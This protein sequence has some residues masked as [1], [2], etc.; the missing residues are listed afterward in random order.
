SDGGVYAAPGRT[1]DW[2]LG[3]LGPGQSRAV[4]IKVLA[5]KPGDWA[6]QA[7]ARA[8]WGLEAKAAAPV[9]VEGVPGLLLAVADLD[10]P[11][12]VGA[13]TTYEI[14]VLN[15][16]SGACSQVQIRAV[17]PD[18]MAVVG[19]EPAA[20]GVQGQEVV[21]DPVAK[22]AGRADVVF[23]VKV[24]AKAAGDWRFKA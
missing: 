2:A 3:S 12:E 23:R 21:F 11:V 24:R 7:L 1:V 4:T 18:G 9:H 5:H 16:G 8:D 14:R 17:V 19:T 10:D 15:Q 22:L 6:N 13:E 20:H